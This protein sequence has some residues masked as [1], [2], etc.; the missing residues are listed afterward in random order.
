MALKKAGGCICISVIHQ[1]QLLNCAQVL[2]FFFACQKSLAT[3]ELAQLDDVPTG[4]LKKT[5]F[6]LAQAVVGSE[7]LTATELRFANVASVSSNGGTFS[8]RHQKEELDVAFVVELF[9]AYI[10]DDYRCR[11]WLRGLAQRG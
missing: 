11:T 8:C 10:V 2:L 9:A 7:V 3:V 1:M 4:G 5:G 6:Q